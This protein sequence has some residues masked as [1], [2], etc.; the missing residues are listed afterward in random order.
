MRQSLFLGNNDRLFLVFAQSA[1]GNLTVDLSV[2]SIVNTDAYIL[3][4]V[5]LGSTLS[6]ENSTGLNGLSVRSLNAETFG[7][8]ISAVFG[9]AQTFF[10][11]E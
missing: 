9:A 7:F 1:V 11:S 3:S 5:D 8:G 4:G 6:Y 10:M 2:K